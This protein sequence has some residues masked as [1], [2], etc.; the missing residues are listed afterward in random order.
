[1][2]VG[3]LNFILDN[4]EKQGGNE[5]LSSASAMIQTVIQQIGLIDLKFQGD[6]FTWSNQREGDA[7]IRERIDI[8]L[9]NVSW[10]ENFPDSIIHHLTRV[11]SDHSHLFIEIDPARLRLS[12]HYKY[13]RGWKEHKEYDLFFENAWKKNREESENDIIKTFE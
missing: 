7:N 10:F 9:V 5:A 13:F 12:R 4:S 6:P 11:A 3:D 8:S 1:M 2:L